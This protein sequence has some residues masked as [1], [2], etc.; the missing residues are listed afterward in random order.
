[1]LSAIYFNLDQSEILSSGNGLNTI[2]S[3]LT[4]CFA[5]SNLR[6]SKHQIV[7]RKEEN[8]LEKGETRAFTKCD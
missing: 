8:I 2:Q 3:I 1:M 7:F 4:K 6:A 5:L